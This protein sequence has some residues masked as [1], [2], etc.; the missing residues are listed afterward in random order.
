M[1]IPGRGGRP[2]E[3]DGGR[4]KWETR[5][6]CQDWVR[7]RM[8]HTEPRVWLKT[9]PSGGASLTRYEVPRWPSTY[10]VP[11]RRGSLINVYPYPLRGRRQAGDRKLLDGDL[12]LD[13]PIIRRQS[14]PWRPISTRP[15]PPSSFLP[16][17]IPSTFT[18]HHLTHNILV[19]HFTISIHHPT[20]YPLNIHHRHPHNEDHFRRPR[21]R[22]LRRRPGACRSASV[23]CRCPIQ[24]T[25]QITADVW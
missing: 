8:R 2:R 3:E 6:Y 4:G 1:A 14:P 17:P 7:G 23:R 24:F 13:R 22:R 11:G 25:M 16:L 15:P 9:S 21:R 18:S 5:N 19:L 10:L 20:P 12:P